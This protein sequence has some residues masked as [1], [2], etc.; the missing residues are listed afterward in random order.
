MKKYNLNEKIKTLRQEDFIPFDPVRK[1][2]EATVIQDSTKFSVA[3]GA[4]Q[5]IL[6]MCKISEEDREKAERMV[7]GYA[8]HGYLTLGIAVKYDKDWIF[9]GLLPLFDPPRNDAPHAIKAIKMM[10]VKIKMVTGDH[11]SIAKHIGEMLGLGRK[12]VSMGELSEKRQRGMD[13]SSLAEETDIFAEVFPE[14]KYDIVDALQKKGHLVAMTGDGVNDAPAL[15]KANCGIAVSGATDAARAAAAVALL[16]PGLS[17]IVDAIKEARK[18]FARMESYVVYRI[19]ETI[20]VLFFIALSIMVFNFYPITAL[21]IVLIAILNDIPILTIAYDNVK[22]HDKPV[23][24]DMH[25]VLLLSSLLGIAGVISSFLLFYIAKDVLLLG[26]TTIQT[27]IFLK[28][29]VAGHLTIFITRSEKF[30][31]S[32]PYPSGMLFWSAVITKVIATLIA[33]YGIFVTPI[34]WWL[35]LLIWGYAL[36][37]MFIMDQVKAWTLKYIKS[38]Y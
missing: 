26:Y 15:K 12:T 4:P 14:H 13:V 2:T 36:I 11:A 27:F 22:V 21:M 25:K 20:R 34:N 30:L 19:T 8:K 38:L 3:K 37:W 23:K 18:I 7:E 10:G 9:V 24:W 17:V 31:W 32:K 29:A 16:Q 28:L 6:D 5:I 35:I 33:A 1:R